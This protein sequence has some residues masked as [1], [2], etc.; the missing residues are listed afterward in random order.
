MADDTSSTADALLDHSASPEAEPCCKK[1]RLDLSQTP[2]FVGDR[3]EIQKVA[4]PFN[5]SEGDMQPTLNKL[6]GTNSNDIGQ[7]MTE[8]DAGITEY[9]SSHTGFTA[10][11]KQ[12]FSDFL[13]NEIDNSGKTVRLTDVSKPQCHQSQQVGTHC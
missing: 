6:K 1:A 2:N 7:V 12:R 4:E 13:V 9:I 5:S 8:K 3:D 10:V 11:I